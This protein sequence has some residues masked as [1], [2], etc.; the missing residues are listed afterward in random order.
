MV[1]WD[2][3]FIANGKA[4]IAFWTASTD[5]GIGVYGAG[6]N[7]GVV[8][9]CENA[10]AVDGASPIMGVK[11][12]SP[13]IGVNGVGE[14]VK[15]IEENPEDPEHPKVTVQISTTAGVLGQGHYDAY[16]VVGICFAAKDP[17]TIGEGIGTLGVSNANSESEIREGRG[18]GV[19]GLSLNDI[20]LDEGPTTLPQL[21]FVDANKRAT[22]DMPGNGTGVWGLSGGGTGVHGQSTGGRGGVFESDEVAQ[23]RLKPNLHGGALPTNGKPGDLFVMWVGGHAE[24]W[25]CGVGDEIGLSAQW[26]RIQVGALVPA[27]PPPPSP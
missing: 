19:V 18:A 1:T 7:A 17:R 25:F 2:N 9:R 12:T 8:G 5:I 10:T 14:A 11:G 21:P 26:Q 16:G 23:L 4:D 24:L 3:K 20:G 13:R 15:I 22:G 27:P 6:Q